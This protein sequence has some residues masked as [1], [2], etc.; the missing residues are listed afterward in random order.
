MQADQD[1]VCERDLSATES[2]HRVVKVQISFQC[3]FGAR[4]SGSMASCL[5]GKGQAPFYVICVLV[6]ER[7][8]SRC[9]HPT[10][11][12]AAI[13]NNQLVSRICV[14]IQVHSQ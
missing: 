12:P 11:L 4:D 13:G 8:L 5:A 9:S 10:Y 6:W 3:G 2:A 7:T 14:G 1:C